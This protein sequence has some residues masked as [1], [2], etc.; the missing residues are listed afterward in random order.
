MTRVEFYVDGA[1]KGSDASAPYSLALD[2]TTLAD[3]SHSLVA[4][5]YDAAGNVGSSSAVAFSVSNASAPVQLI[6]NGGFESGT[7]NWTQTSGVIT[8]DSSEPAHAG[9]W[10]AW[11]DGYGSAHSDYVRQSISI[12][13]GASHATLGFQLHVDT[14]ESGSTAYDKLQVQVIDSSGKYVTLASFSNTDAASG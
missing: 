2:S 6:L 9:S 12:P 1:L 3:G 5:A 14:A 7:A 11:L 8:S 4:K 10:K 13:A